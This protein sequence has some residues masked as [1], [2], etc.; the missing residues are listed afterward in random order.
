[1]NELNTQYSFCNTGVR[2]DMKNR[3]ASLYQVSHHAD[4]I[5]VLLNVMVYSVSTSSNIGNNV[6]KIRD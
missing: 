4:S 3:K 6:K 5:G 1:M 2:N